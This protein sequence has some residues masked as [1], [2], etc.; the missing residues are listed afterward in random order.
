MTAG[1]S[2]NILTSECETYSHTISENMSNCQ[3]MDYFIITLQNYVFMFLMSVFFR[4]SPP[5]S[6]ATVA[7]KRLADMC[8]QIGKGM[9][10]LASKMIVHRDLA[11]RNCM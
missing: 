3:S 11:A 1:A 8:I 5:L 9:E 4:I 10:Y 2:Y 7:L 6:K